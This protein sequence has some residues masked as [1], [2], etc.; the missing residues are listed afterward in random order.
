V[1]LSLLISYVYALRPSL[2]SLKS[3]LKGTEHRILFF[4]LLFLALIHAYLVPTALSIASL[5]TCPDA[6]ITLAKFV[7]TSLVVFV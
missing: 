2:R 4:P 3:V 1:S 7:I 6:L 5:G